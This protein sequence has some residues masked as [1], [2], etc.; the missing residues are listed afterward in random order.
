V[1]VYRALVVEMLG[2][3]ADQPYGLCR[4]DQKQ[5]GEKLSAP[6]TDDTSGDWVR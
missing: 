5:Y 3:S 6:V 1:S 4:R 2:D